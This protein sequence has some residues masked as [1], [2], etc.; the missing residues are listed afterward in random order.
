MTSREAESAIVALGLDEEYTVR[1][2]GFLAKLY[3]AEGDLEALERLH[4]EAVEGSIPPKTLTNVS[5]VL[6]MARR[7]KSMGRPR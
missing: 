3:R 7:D 5:K 6:K 2:Y 1:K 4:E